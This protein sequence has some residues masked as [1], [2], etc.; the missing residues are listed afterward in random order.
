MLTDLPNDKSFDDFIDGDKVSFRERSK[1]GK[2]G[3]FLKDMLF[4]QI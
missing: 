2:K 1:N 4:K 3:V